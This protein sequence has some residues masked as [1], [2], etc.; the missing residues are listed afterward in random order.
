[1]L[2]VVLDRDLVVVVDQD[3]V[4]QLLGAGE[5][6]R[7]AADA[8]LEVAVGGE[9][10]DGVVEQ[11][12]ALGGVRV[13]QAALAAGGH[14]HADGVADAL[15]QRAGRRLHARGVVD[16]G[17]A[18]GQGTPGAQRLQVGEL[19]AVAGEVEL[20]VEG[21]ARVPHRQDEA[22]AARPSSDRSGRAAATSG[23]A[24]RPSGAMLIAVPGWP[25]PTFW[26]ASMAS[27]R[28]VSIARR[29]SSPMPSGSVGC[30]WAGLPVGVS[31]AASAGASGR[32]L[33]VPVLRSDSAVM[34]V[35]VLPRVG[36]RARPEPADG[37]RPDGTTCAVPRRPAAELHRPY[38]LRPQHQR[39]QP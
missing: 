23:T 8:L 13:E 28:T 17:V 15:A 5:R 2:G 32:V 11:A 25:L 34:Q 35:P 3:Q 37:P 29:S 7:L 18:R 39:D 21:E 6:R 30:G 27:T 12:L 26:T 22:V 16:L 4:A 9:R 24:G 1:M 20:D 19:Q 38:P 10:P 33:S 31:L 14:R 36:Q